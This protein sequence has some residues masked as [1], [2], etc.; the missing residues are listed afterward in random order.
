MKPEWFSTNLV[1]RKWP[2]E[3]STG[4]LFHRFE[5]GRLID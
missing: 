4:L 5:N 1:G 3:K 2:I